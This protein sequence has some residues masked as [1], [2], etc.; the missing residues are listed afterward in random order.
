MS[1]TSLETILLDWIVTAVI[2]ACIKKTSKL[3]NFHAAIFNIN[4]ER[5]YAT[6]SAYFVLFISREVKQQLK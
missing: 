4:D 1:L 3:V 6:F 2:S 5:I